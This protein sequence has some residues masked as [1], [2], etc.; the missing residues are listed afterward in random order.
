M[1]DDIPLA[2]HSVTLLGDGPV[3]PDQLARALR[4]APILVAADGGARH[5]HSLGHPVTRIV[6]DLDSLTNLEFWRDQGAELVQI[7]EQDS[8]DFEKCLYSV[9]AGLYIGLGFL[10]RRLDHTLAC[11]RSLAAYPEKPVVLVGEDDV[12]FLAPVEVAL[13]LPAGMRVSVFPLGAVSCGPSTGL[14]WQLDGL[15]MA[16]D[17]KIGTSNAA[18]GGPVTMRFD[19]P[20]ALVMLPLAAFDQVIGFMGR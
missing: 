4:L 18:L 20:A 8:T 9:E 3:D 14:R 1:R 17:G 13:D 16:P 10:G 11:L 15:E 6:G 5:A 12:V 2:A 19:R 7:D